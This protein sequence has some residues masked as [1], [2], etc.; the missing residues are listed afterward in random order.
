M[1]KLLRS[2]VVDWD[3]S[4]VI[5]ENV[6]YRGDVANGAEFSFRE[7]KN[8][9]FDPDFPVLVLSQFVHDNVVERVVDF[10]SVAR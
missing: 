5:E 4:E 9:R 8:E 10:K 7:A 3:W 1:Q 6:D 2:V